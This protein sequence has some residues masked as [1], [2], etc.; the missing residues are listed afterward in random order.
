M[1][2]C[3]IIGTLN[4]VTYKDFFGL[5]KDDKV[6]LGFTHR[7]GGGTKIQPASGRAANNNKRYLVDYATLHYSTTY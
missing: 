7:G 6:R 1:K 3:L 2:D 5:V 4:N